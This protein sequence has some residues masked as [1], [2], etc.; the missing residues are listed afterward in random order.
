MTGYLIGVDRKIPDWLIKIRFP[1][2]VRSGVKSG[3]GAMALS[4]L[5]PFGASAIWASL[6]M[7]KRHVYF[8]LENNLRYDVKNKQTTTKK[9]LTI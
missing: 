9:R 4:T 6:T 2:G 8:V 1:G 3:F 5:M 7:D